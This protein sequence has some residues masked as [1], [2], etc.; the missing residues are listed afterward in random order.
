[1]GYENA[2]FGESINA[3]D[4]WF[5]I[6]ESQTETGTPYILFKDSCNRKSNQKNLGT[7]KS[8]NLC[9]EIIEY[10]DPGETAV[11]NLASINLK[12]LI[13]HDEI[14]DEFT[15][16]TKTDCKYCKWAKQYLKSKKICFEEITIDANKDEN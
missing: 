4:L 15:I 5:K 13:V 10:S 6:L 12:N 2:G 3:Q 14:D 11:C 1:M 8:S 7:I 16:Y 9:T